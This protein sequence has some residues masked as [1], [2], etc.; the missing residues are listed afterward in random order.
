[1]LTLYTFKAC[2]VGMGVGENVGIGF[3]SDEFIKD[4]HIY[5]I[6]EFPYRIL[7]NLIII[8][9]LETIVGVMELQVIVTK[10]PFVIVKL[11]ITPIK[12]NIL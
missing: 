7:W 4:L 10:L 8:L 5:L 11:L 3:V 6:G 2:V 1:M 12:H 9:D